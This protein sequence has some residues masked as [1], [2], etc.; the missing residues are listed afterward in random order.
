MTTTNTYNPIFRAF[1]ELTS[2]QAFRWYLQQLQTTATLAQTIAHY[3]FTTAQRL[4][5]DRKPV[6]LAAIAEPELAQTIAPVVQDDSAA[7][8]GLENAMLTLPESALEQEYAPAIDEPEAVEGDRLKHFP[9]L[10][11]GSTPEEQLELNQPAMDLLQSWIETDKISV[12]ESEN[13]IAPSEAQT[14]APATAPE[15]DDSEGDRIAIDEPEQAISLS[16]A[17]AIAP[18]PDFGEAIADDSKADAEMA[19]G[20]DAP[21]DD[22]D[23]TELRPWIDDEAEAELPSLVQ[24]EEDTSF[25]SSEAADEYGQAKAPQPEY[26]HFSTATDG[27][28]G[29]RD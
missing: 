23:D 2:A 5:S 7:V 18:E 26:A 17:E 9:G 22:D 6:A 11:I 13:A 1:R 29:A 19:W 10:R 24:E 21:L 8:A 20:D 4:L 28:A 27:V 12:A 14:I 25:Y 15:Q 16:D 3:S